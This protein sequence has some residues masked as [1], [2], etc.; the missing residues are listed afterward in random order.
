MKLKLL[1]PT[2][3]VF[4][5]SCQFGFS[6]EKVGD[7]VTP[8]ES[9]LTPQDTEKVIFAETLKN[10]E[11]G[12]TQAG[13]WIDGQWR[14]IAKVEGQSSSKALGEYQVGQTHFVLGERV[15]LKGDQE[16]TQRGVW[17]NNDW[18]ELKIPPGSVFLEMNPD[19]GVS[20]EGQI[21]VAG[22]LRLTGVDKQNKPPVNGSWIDGEWKDF[23]EVAGVK[24]LLDLGPVIF[25]AGSM[26]AYGSFQKNDD[27]TSIGFWGPQGWSWFETLLPNQTLESPS[28]LSTQA[29]PLVLGLRRK[30]ESGQI[31]LIEGANQASVV[32]APANHS[33]LGP[34]FLNRNS[35]NSQLLVATNFLN[36]GK[37]RGAY[38]E[39][40]G[41]WKFLDETSPENQNL[42]YKVKL[43]KDKF[44]FYGARKMSDSKTEIGV[45]T[46]SIFKAYVLPE[47][48]DDPQGL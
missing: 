37:R 8:S 44:H 2:F 6:Y 23:P 17:K 9:P 30:K 22:R 14:G 16:T 36:E 10:S 3:L 24:K 13:R 7:T 41:D 34:L 29:M 46:D 25:S 47:N 18:M 19:F 28:L 39:L 11:N 31:V 15:V 5:A 12:T 45:W 26:W 21:Q 32:E 38:K 35:A 48:T 33:Y 40:S 1:I 20:G 42:I 4:L 27:V 43:Y